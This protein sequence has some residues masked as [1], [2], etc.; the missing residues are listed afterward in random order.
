MRKML[1]R[2]IYLA[3]LGAML[4]S[5]VEAAAVVGRPLTPVSYAGVA[6]RTARRTAYRAPVAVGAA[7]AVGTAAALTALPPGCYVGVP[8]AGVVYRPAYQGTTV[9]YVV[10]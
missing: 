9:V 7:A 10:Q 5:G 3:A 4:F 1:R 8:C 6:R 2:G